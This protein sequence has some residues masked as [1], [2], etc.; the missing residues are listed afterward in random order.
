MAK[1]PLSK[2]SKEELIRENQRIGKD[3]A[4]SEEKFKREQT[5]V[6]RAL[7]RVMALESAERVLGE[8]TPAEREAFIE[9]LTKQQ[10]G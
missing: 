5:K 4:A 7:D 1:K 9:T 10:G 8:M 2:M 6:N 3:R